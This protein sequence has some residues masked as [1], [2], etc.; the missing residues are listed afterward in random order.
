YDEKAVAVAAVRRS[1]GRSGNL[2]RGLE[3]PFSSPEG[4]L[5]ASDS[6]TGS[7]PPRGNDVSGRPRPK[8][9]RPPVPAQRTPAGQGLPMRARQ[10]PAQPGS[11]ARRV[12]RS[13]FHAVAA[14]PRGMMT[15][16]HPILDAT[17]YLVPL[18]HVSLPVNP[19]PA[20]RR[21]AFNDT[22]VQSH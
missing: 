12:S 1:Q 5:P 13:N 21:F 22:L 18:Q 8:P 11:G 9:P 17:V 4:W 10:R 2:V 15:H 7:G 14:S 20:G 19:A 6:F 3:A 16:L